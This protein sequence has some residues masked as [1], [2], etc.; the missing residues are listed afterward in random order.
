MVCNLI[1]DKQTCIKTWHFATLENI[2]KVLKCKKIKYNKSPS[3][4]ISS[5]ITSQWL[6]KNKNKKQLCH[7]ILL[8]ELSFYLYFL[9]TLS[10]YLKIR[11]PS[12]NPQWTVQRLSLYLINIK[13]SHNNQ[14]I[15]IKLKKQTMTSN[16]SN[17]QTK[18]IV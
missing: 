11:N 14:L 13:L 17:Y 15:K 1:R 12:G 5:S 7:V 8:K 4:Q 16:K 10:G 18:W 2:K 6:E 9:F 3:W